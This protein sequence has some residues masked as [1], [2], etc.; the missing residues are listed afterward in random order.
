[1][2]AIKLGEKVLIEVMNLC[3]DGNGAS[4]WSDNS[5]VLEIE[6]VIYITFSF[7]TGYPFNKACFEK[8]I[9]P[10]KR[11]GEAAMVGV[12]N[13]FEK[14]MFTNVVH[15]IGRSWTARQHASCLAK[16]ISLCQNL[17]GKLCIVSVSATSREKMW[18]T[19]KDNCNIMWIKRCF[20]NQE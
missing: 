18:S 17:S 15:R 7:D 5:N 13:M 9:I 6:S 3:D 10:T 12:W 2:N 20:T 11:P 1:M 4:N 16:L 14:L 8:N 19:L